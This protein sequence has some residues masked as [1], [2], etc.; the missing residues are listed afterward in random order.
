MC[1]HGVSIS[2]RNLQV[3]LTNSAVSNLYF[4]PRPLALDTVNQFKHFPSYP[5][6]IRFIFV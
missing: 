3:H 2:L 5:L 4:V 1:L 6:S